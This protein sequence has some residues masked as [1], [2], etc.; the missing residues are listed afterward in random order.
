MLNFIAAGNGLHAAVL[1]RRLTDETRGLRRKSVNTDEK[2]DFAQY[3]AEQ[4]RR[5]EAETMEDPE[6]FDGMW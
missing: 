4:I 5:R 3:L 2:P 1:S 6:R